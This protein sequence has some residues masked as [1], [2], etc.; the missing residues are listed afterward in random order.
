ME[1]R[2]FNNMYMLQGKLLNNA[3]FFYFKD[4]KEELDLL[5]TDIEH[6]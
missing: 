6:S 5:Q 1:T 3:Y 2:K 4:N